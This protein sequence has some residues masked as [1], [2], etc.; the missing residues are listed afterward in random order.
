MQC[1]K[2]SPFECH[3]L[4][5]RNRKRQNPYLS[6]M[7]E[8]YETYHEDVDIQSRLP[9]GDNDPYI[10]EKLSGNDLIHIFNNY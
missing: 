10:V 9:P 1:N 8:G 6:Q 7:P 2:S 3:Q 4:S 5:T